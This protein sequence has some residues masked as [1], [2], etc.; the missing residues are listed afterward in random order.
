[1]HPIMKAIAPG[2][3]I[4]SGEHSV[5]YGRPALAMAV[6]RNAETL[7]TLDGAPGEVSFE[8]P[9][10][11]PARE[12]FTLRALRDFHDRVARSHREFLEGRLSIRDVLH[13]PVELFQYAYITLLDG[14]HLTVGGT[15]GVNV[16]MRSNIP[17]GCGM[18]SSAASIMSVLRGLGH[19]YRVE[20]RPE[21]YA[22]Y[23]LEVE[24]MQH[25]RASGLDTFV[26]L[27]G[28]CVLF[29]QG[30]FRELPLPRVPLYIVNTGHP[31]STTG[32]AVSAVARRTG[33]ASS[34]L[35]D[36]FESATLAMEKATREND[37]PG[38]QRAM[39]TNHRL[40]DAI[41]VVPPRVA[42]FVAEVE[43]TG[44]AAKVCGAGAVSGD[45]A[46]MVLVAS[47][48]SPADL[49]ARHGYELMTVRPDPLGVRIV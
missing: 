25:G 36:E 13:K 33:G 17:I 22:R 38:F 32:E 23:S 44:A 20:F 34:P 24:N 30:E 9:D 42:E 46:G 6:N 16:R 35:W 14:L 26:S 47:E 5:V 3:L 11:G 18:G 19:Y 48:T 2:K 8:L 21:W 27:H 15:G 49:C 41:G 12:S 31:A 39:R 40:L 4:L 29:R 43:A 1:M 28:G 10:L 7:V 45:A 37:L